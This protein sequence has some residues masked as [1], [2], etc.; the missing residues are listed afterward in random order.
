MKRR[1]AALALSILLLA[2]YLLYDLWQEQKPRLMMSGAADESKLA[3]VV[4]PASDNPELNFDV[5]GFLQEDIVY[6]FLPCRMNLSKVVYYSAD[7]EGNYLERFRTDFRQGEGKIGRRRVIA[8][9]SLLPSMNIEIAENAKDIQEI[10]SEEFHNSFTYG[11]MT[12]EVTDADAALRGWPRVYKSVENEGDSPESLKMRGRGNMTWSV[13]KKS[14]QIRLEKKLDLL[15]M[16]KAK[17][18]VLLANAMDYSL[19]RNEVFLDLARDIGMDYTPEI[20]PVDLFING[21]YRGSY[22]LCSKIQIS[23]TRVAINE[24]RDYLYRWGMEGQDYSFPL[25]SNT[26]RNDINKIAGLE[27]TD[28]ESKV[29]P[30]G[31]IAQRV[32]SA[33]EDVGSDDYLAMI[34]LTSWAQ[35]YWVQEFSKNTDATLRSVYTYWIDSEQRMYMGPVWDLDRTAGAVEPADKEHDYIWPD[36]WSV[37]YEDWFQALFLHGEFVDEVNRL[38]FDGGV[39]EAFDRVCEELPEK[40]ERVRLSEAMNEILW[41]PFAEGGIQYNVQIVNTMGENS[42]GAQT[43]WLSKW[44][45]MRRDFIASEME[46]YYGIPQ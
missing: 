17:K 31:E 19:L 39:K 2:V 11:D 37:K 26:I 32:L 36:G 27:D 22:A 42:Y 4:V 9:Q 3:E 38:Y 41:N 43:E 13:D 35:Y 5:K 46:K 34:D 23:N 14:Y 44:I 20:E 10:D 6:L 8:M 24:N 1:K 33:I 29:E 25:S 40:I 30:A 16:G 15:G 28:D 18:W 7:S 45:T 12:L 21:E